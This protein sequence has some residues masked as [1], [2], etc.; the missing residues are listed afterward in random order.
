MS[1]R[2][3]WLETRVPPPVVLLLLGAAAWLFARSTPELLFAWPAHQWIAGAFAGVGLVLNLW[4][5][6]AFRRAQ[7]T[8]NPLDPS[9]SS[10]LVTTG[11]Y[12][13]SRNPMYLGHS[14]ILLGW[15]VYLQHAAAFV[16]V[17][18]FM[19]YITR[20]QIGPEERVLA[21]RFA[22]RYDAFRGRVR[23]WL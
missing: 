19:A 13:Y 15:A 10:A 5:K 1:V 11:V 14:L 17:P 2:L 12:R 6:F 9:A 21:A 7:T 3:S 18:A 23:R 20:F 16:A 22:D 8:V 4:P